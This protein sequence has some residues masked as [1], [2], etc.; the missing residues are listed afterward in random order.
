MSDDSP[1]AGIDVEFSRALAKEL[2]AEARFFWINPEEKNVEEALLSGKCDVAVGAVIDDSTVD[3]SLPGVAKTIPYF[4]DGFTIIRRADAK[5]VKNLDEISDERIA[6]EGESISNI[7]LRQ[8]GRQVFVR[9]DAEDVIN[10][11]ANGFVRYGYIWNP[12][13]A[14]LLRDRKD[15]I[16]EGQFEPVDKW[17][18]ALA[19]RKNE[20]KKLEEINRAIRKLIENGT[21]QKIFLSNKIPYS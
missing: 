19:V 3:F 10:S 8:R 17:D 6:V 13:A 15:I 4:T 18:F 12:L 11:L 16:I 1:S 7:A 9:E 21:V 14:Y 5:P 20:H 2:N